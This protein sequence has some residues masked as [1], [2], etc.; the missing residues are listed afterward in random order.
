M[1][2]CFL[3]TGL[4][5]SKWGIFFIY[6]SCGR[7]KTI[8]D[9]DTLSSIQYKTKTNRKLGMMAHVFNPCTQ[10]TEAKCTQG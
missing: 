2:T 6:G 7:I 10:E 8:V 5:T 3:Q 4:E 1:R 9:I